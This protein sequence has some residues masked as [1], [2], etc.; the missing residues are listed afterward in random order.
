MVC[1]EVYHI[2][3]KSIDAKSFQKGDVAGTAQSVFQ[4]VRISYTRIESVGLDL[5]FD[6]PNKE[7]RT[8]ILVE[9]VFTLASLASAGYS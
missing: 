2:Y 5:V 8:R 7:L 9:K 1:V 4:S 3:Q 6:S